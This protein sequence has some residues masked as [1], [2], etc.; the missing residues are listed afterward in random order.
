MVASDD[1]D[2]DQDEESI[3]E[4]FKN[5]T[6]TDGEI[7]VSLK[8]PKFTVGS[9][10]FSTFKWKISS[11]TNSQDFFYLFSKLTTQN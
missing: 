1:D 3:H 10:L 8:F 11:T 7:K 2:I 5:G 9:S 4:P 6:F